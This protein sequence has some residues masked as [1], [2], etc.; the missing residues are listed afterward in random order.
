[1]TIEFLL[2]EF[3]APSGAFLLP[4]IGGV[5]SNDYSTDP[6]LEPKGSF[7]MPIL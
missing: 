1:M 4:K 3:I 7:L 5:M 6:P 2:F